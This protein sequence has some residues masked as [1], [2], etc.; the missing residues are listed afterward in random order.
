MQKCFSLWGTRPPGLHPWTPLG[1]SCSQTPCTSLHHLNWNDGYAYACCSSI[2]ILNF[3]QS[4]TQWTP[5]QLGSREAVQ[6]VGSCSCN[7]PTRGHHRLGAECAI[8]CCVCL[9]PVVWSAVRWRRRGLFVFAGSR[10]WDC[11]QRRQ[12]DPHSHHQLCYLVSF[13]LVKPCGS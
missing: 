2:L 12:H 8:Y 5:Y 1:D 9:D 6:T 13:L 4:P 7:W 3:L 11:R 10:P